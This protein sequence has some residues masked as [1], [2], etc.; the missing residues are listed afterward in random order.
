MRS[1][2]AFPMAVSTVTGVDARAGLGWRWMGICLAMGFLLWVAPAGAETPCGS[3]AVIPE[4]QPALRSECEVLWAFYTSLD[5]PGILDDPDNP[6][7]WLPTV[8][9]SQ[10]AGVLVVDEAVEELILPSSGLEGLLSPQLGALTKLV[11]LD[12][13]DN[14]LR[15]SIPA[16]LAGLGR[17]EYLFLYNNRLSGPVPEELGSLTHLKVLELS[18]NELSGPIPPQLDGL[19]GL[20]GLFL[21]GNRLS[22]PLPKELGALNK[23]ERL[24]LQGNRLDGAI[25]PE[26]GQLSELVS[27]DLSMNDLSGPVPPE[28]GRLPKLETLRLH[29]NRLSASEAAGPFSAEPL[30]PAPPVASEGP[31]DP[32]GSG[33]FVD[34]DGSVH[35]KNIEVIAA[36]GMTVGC[37]PPE[38]DRFCPQS[39]VN[40]AQM[41]A[42]LS[43][44]LGGTAGVDT[45]GAQ[46][47]DVP[48]DAWYFGDVQRMIALGVV[49]LPED[50]AFRPLE[51]LTRIEMAVFLVRAFPGLPGVEE[52]VGAFSDVPATWGEAGAVEAILDAG[53]TSGCSAEP[54]SYCPDRPVT[55][56]QM[57]SFLVQALGTRP[58][59]AGQ[60]T[61]PGSGAPVR[62]ARAEWPSGNFQAALYRALLVELGYEV[63]DPAD[64]ELEPSDAYVG[65]A[66]GRIDFWVDGWYPDHDR[67]MD[68]EVGDG[69]RVGDHVSPVGAQMTAGGLRGFI[70]SK[71][72]AEEHGIA[73]IDDLD[74]N[75]GA[76]VAYD[77]TDVNPQNGLADI[78]GCPP[79]W[80]CY[81][82]I[83]SIIEFSGW[84]NID[85][86]TG[87][88]E[89]M[90]ADALAKIRQGTPVI[91][92]VWTPGSFVG[93][94]APGREVV[95]IGAEHVLDDSNPLSRPG[96]E[97]WDQ[98]PGQVPVRPSMCPG[99]GQ[100]G[101]CRLGWRASDIRVT[102]SDEFLRT[103]PAARRLFELVRLDP[104]DVSRQIAMQSRG[105]DVAELASR[106]VAEHRRLV[107]VWLA[108]SL[109]AAIVQ[110][111]SQ[112]E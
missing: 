73:T 17:L 65:M 16:E 34:D 59:D 52:P 18:G 54:L 20:E 83:D 99:A 62:M 53:V 91:A 19:A 42:L 21:H 96:G 100:S 7:A 41:A 94:M 69:S 45:A 66:E 35:E 32:S 3:D 2:L 55:R 109:I 43:R 33:R 64:L 88:Y 107:D 56:A 58:E 108:Q 57:A 78:Y 13:G 38:N 5:D 9:F 77:E 30:I 74:R 71:A 40:R 92:Y 60:A 22:G 98:R 46:A 48:R 87:T 81:D 8:P 49:E 105:A 51:P 63:G 86:V 111:E 36:L 47:T 39:L 10:W 79:S 14:S 76:L 25:P 27:L 93:V 102:A 50:G 82:I 85:H 24:F 95:W 67:F 68:L 11:A 90:H 97:S 104:L 70:V 28:L 112:P 110:E 12:L 23:L 29:G 6:S 4:S 72:F 103:N 61:L 106:W 84:E 37:N 80:A 75:P 1:R 44:A 26:L 101:T 89:S 15:G 31:R